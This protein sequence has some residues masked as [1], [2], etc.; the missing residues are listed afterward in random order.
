MNSVISKI[1]HS[2]SLFENKW[3]LK[4]F[5]ERNALALSQ[6][7]DLTSIIGKLLS[8]RNVEEEDIDFYLNPNISNHVPDPNQI[9]DMD[10]AIKRVAEATI[11]NQKIGIIADYDVDGSTSASIL[12]KFLKHYNASIILRIPNRLQDGYGPNIKLMREM[13]S[14]DV[15]LLFTLDCGTT[16]NHIIDN[17]EFKKIDVI[18]IDHHLSEFEIPKVHS[19]INPNRFDD[20]SDF[21]QM[22]AVGVTF[23]FLMALR[24][25][26]RNYPKKQ[27]E[28]NGHHTYFP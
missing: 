4:I 15:D 19:I 9:K 6:K 23:L 24:K 3:K 18:V 2:S 22:A 10:I 28:P 5:D 11:K 21:K 7:F 8:I 25:E 26:L 17:I 20:E 16:A 12:F 1:E 14:E 13:L 27:T